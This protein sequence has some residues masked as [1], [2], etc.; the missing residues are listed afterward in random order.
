MQSRYVTF[1]I[2]QS[3]YVAFALYI[4]ISHEMPTL[5]AK[6]KR[7]P[8]ARLLETDWSTERGLGWGYYASLERKRHQ[9]DQ[10]TTDAGAASSGAAVSL[11]PG[12]QRDHHEDGSLDFTAAQRVG[13]ADIVSM[14]AA[15]RRSLSPE[16]GSVASAGAVALHGQAQPANETTADREPSDSAQVS[17]LSMRPRTG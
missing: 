10:A 15:V 17:G 4:K 12:Q 5:Q 1:A 16:D 6:R 3:R 13:L 2:M 7:K 14:A 11:P 8:P 9:P